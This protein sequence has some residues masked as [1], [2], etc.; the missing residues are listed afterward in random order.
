MKEMG[1]E[2]GTLSS[3]GDLQSKNLTPKSRFTNKQA[4]ERGRY[5][6]GTKK[7]P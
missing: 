1:N 4:T 6:D 5:N 7:R 2:L 3:V